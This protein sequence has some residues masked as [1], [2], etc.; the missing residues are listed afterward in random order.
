MT[1]T[2][3]RLLDL[4]VEEHTLTVP[5]VW[6]DPAD[7]RTIDIFARVV[8]REGGERLPYLVFLQGGP[9][10]EAPRPFHSSTS[11]AWLD[12]ALAHYR[13][14]MLDQRGTGLS[15]PVGDAD[16]DRGSAAVAEYLTHLRADSIVR[17]C[18]AMREHLSAETWSVLGQSFGG[19]TTLAYLSSDADSLADVF[20][21]GGL[22]TVDRH[23][24][25]VYALCYD[26]M[27]AASERYYR[28]FPEHRDVMRRLVDQ[29]AAGEIVLPDGEVVSP[30]RLR[31]VG[32]ALGT[33][34]GW[35][36]VWSLL[37]RDPASNAFRHDLM[38][39]MPYGGRNPLYFAFHESS[40]AS[41]H[42]TRWSAERTE[43]QDFRDDVTLFTGEHIRREWTETVP[44]FQP[45]RDVTLALADFEW[46]RIYN[47]VAI[48]ASGAT[49]A[50]AVYV[51]D[52]YVPMEFSLETARLLPG[53]E[54]W[55]TSEHEHNG[56]RSGPV[57]T[58]LIDLAHGRRIR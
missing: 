10:H 4:T 23:P 8:T 55:V 1:T 44:A 52:V 21:T 42:A 27:R 24:D 50:A 54:L 3:R 43:P 28:R 51:N 36:T 25:D 53:V 31:S 41:G 33:N 13:V 34:D 45:W 49:G 15:T 18:E 47:E 46:P 37:E 9:G 32:S 40:Y 38:H 56:V 58:H 30:S 17:D 20:I 14:V 39:A 22:S 16:L 26:K 57:L 5:L 12:E 19:F 48:S 35:Q 11:P 7:T 29:A 2:I 6:G